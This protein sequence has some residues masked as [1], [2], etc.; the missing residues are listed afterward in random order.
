MLQR[1]KNRCVKRS[2]VQETYNHEAVKLFKVAKIRFD[3]DTTAA[4]E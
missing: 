1:I 2:V 3:T 4:F